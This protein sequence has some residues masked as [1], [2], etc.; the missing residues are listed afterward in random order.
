MSI[1]KIH[2]REFVKSIPSEEIAV[3]VKQV[4]D[5]INRD[6]A[7]KRPL[8]VDPQAPLFMGLLQARILE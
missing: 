7:G 8:I 5:R 1:I 6:Y 2:D 4:A 3:R